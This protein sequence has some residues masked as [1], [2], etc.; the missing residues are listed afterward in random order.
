MP[1]TCRTIVVWMRR[2]AVFAGLATGA[3]LL[4]AGCWSGPTPIDQN[5]GTDVGAD[6]IPPDAAI[7]DAA[8]VPRGDSATSADGAAVDDASAVSDAR[9]QAT[10]ADTSALDSDSAGPPQCSPTCS[11]VTCGSPDGCGGTCSIG[12]VCVPSCTGVLCGASDGCG[13]V[14]TWGCLCIPSC[15]PLDCGSYDGCGGTCIFGCGCL[16]S[17]GRGDC[18]TSDG[19]GGICNDGC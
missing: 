13:G 4:P 12:C 7:A 2:F 3:T 5:Y 14:C 8:D 10:D 18:G 11:G 17:C 15:G 9:P 16:P 6:F 1:R 19:C